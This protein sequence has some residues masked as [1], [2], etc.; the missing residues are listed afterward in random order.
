MMVL[1]LCLQP[2]TTCLTILLYKKG[3]MGRGRQEPEPELALGLTSYITLYFTYSPALRVVG[4][5]V[6]WCLC[7][8]TD[9]LAN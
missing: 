8:L 9:R 5:E 2:L 7:R 3:G 1:D 6:N 4:A